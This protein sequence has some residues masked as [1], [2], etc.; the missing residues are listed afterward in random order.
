M[1]WGQIDGKLLHETV[2]I[3][4]YSTQYINTWSTR[5]FPE[6]SSAILNDIM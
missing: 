4:F 2:M 3:K 5:L 6:I 1:T